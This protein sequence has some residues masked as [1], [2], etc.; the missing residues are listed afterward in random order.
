MKRL[1][2]SVIDVKGGV[3][4]E[5]LIANFQRLN[6]AKIEWDLPSDK[7]IFEFI[8][9]YFQD[10]LELPAIQTVTDF[11]S[12]STEELERLK[13]ILAAECYVRT[14]FLHL[15]KTLIEKQSNIRGLQLLKESEVILTKG[16]II[17]EGKEKVKKFGLRDGLIHFTQKAN[18]LILPEH[19]ARMHGDLRQDGQEV[20]DEYQTAKVNKDKAWGKFTGLNHIDINCHGL[21]RGEMHV[22]AAYAGHLKCVSGNTTI[23]DHSTKRQW[24]V[25][26]LFEA[27]K[28]PTVTALHREGAKF[29]LLQAKASHLVQNGIRPVYSLKLDSGRAI[30]A[31]SN[32]KFFT[33]Q[34]WK[35]LGELST[36]DFVAVPRKIEVPKPTT[37][38][39]DAE[40]SVIGYL[41][42][43]GH[44]KNDLGLTASNPAIRDDFKRCL[45]EMGLTEGNA[46][47][48]TPTFRDQISKDHAPQVR[49]CKSRGG[50]YHPQIS[51]VRLLLDKL[52]L[53]GKDSYTKFIPKEIFGLSEKQT[54]LLLGALWSTDGSCSAQDYVRKDRKSIKRNNA[55]TYGSCSKV[56]IEGIQTLLLRLGIRSNVCKVNTTYKGKPYTFYMVTLEGNDSKRLFLAHIR[57]VGKEKAFARLGARLLPKSG[58]VI[59]T[60]FIPG[61]RKVKVE[62][63]YY[64]HSNGILGRP[65][66]TVEE[67]R[68]FL[69]KEDTLLREAL[70]GDLDWEKVKSVT[71]VGEEMTYD[72]SV[73]KHHSF[74]ANGIITHNTTFATNWCYNLVTRYRTNVFYGSFEMKYE[75]IRRLIYVLHSANNRWKGLEP[76]KHQCPACPHPALDYRK[77]RDGELTPEEEV[78]YQLVIDDFEHNPEYCH[79]EV[80]C[81]DHDVSIDDVRLQT[82]MLHKQLEVGFV[83]LD[84][85]GLMQ[86]R[87]KNSNYGVELNSVLR[88]SKKFALHFNHGEGVP[89][90]ML[91]QTNRDG[92]SDADKN[93]GIYKMRALSWA[94]EA[95]RSADVVTTTYLDDQLPGGGTYRKNNQTKIGNL[96]NRDNPLFD[97]FM[98]TVQFK[99]R[100]IMNLDITE[101]TG[102]NMSVEDHQM[103]NALMSQV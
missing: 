101:H 64:R 94:S 74:V 13:D 92:L 40:I 75:H 46:N 16:L 72:L 68:R 80:W 100:R 61:N 52:A 47:F 58:R 103:M 96:K 81:P 76:A 39:S 98:A 56:L 4:Q 60:K 69:T 91:F 26:E 18:E 97:P 10:R 6:S 102:A 65:T 93:D 89:T 85:G 50:M 30:E 32:H 44:I 67:A 9:S 49:I 62:K 99:T 24:T 71:Y 82:E 3:S 88:D 78:F 53:Y 33:A 79:F 63:G 84:H 2:R 37:V 19:N 22:H 57:V 77:V 17:Q 8:K 29:K 55:I 1:L 45:Q 87:S 66:V 31:T 38:Y 28:L 15:L 43:D 23:Y 5:H 20:W 41:L 21:K 73:P 7:L 48:T 86:A 27:K 70:E 42:G 51:P 11:F 34:G 90:L 12:N 54:A 36:K 14:N 59:P 83:V 35:E 25:Q 95:E